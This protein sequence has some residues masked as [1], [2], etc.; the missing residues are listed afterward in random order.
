M[1]E[2]LISIAAYKKQNKKPAILFAGR[3]LYFSGITPR[4]M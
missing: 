3:N 2:V 4:F 1:Y